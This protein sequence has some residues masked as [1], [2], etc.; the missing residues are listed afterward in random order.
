MTVPD[1]FFPMLQN[2]GLGAMFMFVFV[3]LI[4]APLIYAAVLGKGPSHRRLVNVIDAFARLVAA[5]KTR[6][7]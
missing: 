4:F 2:G 6:R 7:K 1:G 5:S 3:V